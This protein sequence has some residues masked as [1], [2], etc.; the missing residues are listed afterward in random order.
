MRTSIDGLLERVDVLEAALL[1][2]HDLHE[3]LQRS[4]T[5][6]LCNLEQGITD[7]GAAIDNNGERRRLGW[8]EIDKVE[9]YGLRLDRVQRQSS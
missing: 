3:R 8:E 4:S 2:V 1:R 6:R 7:L 9:V 5:N